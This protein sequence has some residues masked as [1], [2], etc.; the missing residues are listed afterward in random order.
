M[1]AVRG[2]TQASKTALDSAIRDLRGLTGSVRRADEQR[3]W[4]FMAGSGG[5]I[6]GLLLYA[7]LAGPIARMMPAS[8]Q[9]PERMATRVL[10]E[11]TAWTAGRHL[12]ISASPRSW[13]AIATAFNLMDSNRKA[14]ER[15]RAAA[16]KEEKAVRCT[17]EVKGE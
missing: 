10:D 16:A 12:L 9:W 6:A 14:I 2:E 15:C 3:Q 4:L 8:W 1:N 17:I 13:D 5:L 7:L 11:Q